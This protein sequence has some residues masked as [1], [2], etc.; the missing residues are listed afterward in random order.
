M[1]I[2]E[3]IQD[4]NVENIKIIIE[5]GG[6]IFKTCHFSFSSRTSLSLEMQLKYLQAGISV[7][8]TIHELPLTHSLIFCETDEVAHYLL[9]IYERD[10][11][12][13]KGTHFKKALVAMPEDQTEEFLS[14]CQFSVLDDVKFIEPVLLK[15]N[16]LESP[17]LAYLSR[18]LKDKNDQSLKFIKKLEK[19]GSCDLSFEFGDNKTI[20]SRFIYSYKF[21]II[22]RL[23]NSPFVDEDIKNNHK[24]DFLNRYFYDSDLSSHEYLF[25]NFKFD[26]CHITWC[27][28]FKYVKKLNFVLNHM[29]KFQ[30]YSLNDILKMECNMPDHT[31]END[32]SI[33]L[34]EI[35]KSGFHEDLN[36]EFDEEIFYPKDDVIIEDFFNSWINFNED[37]E[38]VKRFFKKYPKIL[39]LKVKENFTVL[40]FTVMTLN[41]EAMK[42]V[43]ELYEDKDI[44][45]KDE[46]TAVKCL[47]RSSKLFCTNYKEATE[48]L[49]LLLQ[50][51]FESFITKHG[52]KI[53]HNLRD[54]FNKIPC[55]KYFTSL[56]FFKIDTEGEFSIYKS[57][58]DSPHD[59]WE[60]F[61]EFI[62]MFPKP[63]W[64][65]VNSHGLTLFMKACSNINDN[66]EFLKSIIDKQPDCVHKR[67]S[68][69]STCLHFV[70]G[71]ETSEIV[72]IMIESGVDPQVMNTEN[73][74]PIFLACN[75]FEI[76]SFLLKFESDEDLN[77]RYGDGPDTLFCSIRDR[78][79]MELFLTRNVDPLAPSYEGLSSIFLQYYDD[80]IDVTFH[81]IKSEKLKVDINMKDNE[82][83]GFLIR[84]IN[85]WSPLYLRLLL[86]YFK[87][88]LDFCTCNNKGENFTQKVMN[89]KNS[90]VFLE[91]F[92]IIKE[93]CLKEFLDNLSDFAE[94]DVS[95][96]FHVLEHFDLEMFKAN[97]PNLINYESV[98]MKIFNQDAL[99]YFFNKLPSTIIKSIRSCNNEKSIEFILTKLNP[100]IFSKTKDGDEN[101]LHVVCGKNNNKI[102]EDFLIFLSTEQINEFSKQTFDGKRP[103]DML[104][105][106]LQNLY[107]KIL[108]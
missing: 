83:N 22:V 25:D 13:L 59:Y 3:N 38:K 41:Y 7:D 1:D 34:Y 45:I 21:D 64:N 39:A 105:D 98:V 82:G 77:T 62:N 100:E 67:T 74:K 107:G 99:S 58:V 84:A 81:H 49:K 19:N 11:E 80:A 54:W 104:N 24:N 37:L 91:F 90:N 71:H 28:N 17:K 57:I 95:N 56:P 94:I 46:D 97:L 51:H 69:N 12:V 48:V 27:T 5:N 85:R 88:D 79:V 44:F 60:S 70:A 47:E 4:N 96:L 92:D 29:I 35:I 6:N 101:I 93:K 30:K 78:E 33:V 23:Y 87:N 86:K 10:L 102:I 61:E 66:P 52:S 65:I 26:Q 50:N 14:C 20:L 106:E 42:M 36:L 31:I 108:N 53:I 103:F 18:K 40:H 9:D 55:A 75:N 63:D 89:V 16:N 72:K 15:K 2:F 8:K 43:F 32:K 68:N 73:I 76:F